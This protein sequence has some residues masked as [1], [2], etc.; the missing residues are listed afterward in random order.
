M[1]K[2]YNSNNVFR[3]VS[4]LFLQL[5]RLQEIK[6]NIHIRE[7]GKRF[8]VEKLSHRRAVYLLNPFIASVSV[9]LSER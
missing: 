1:C 3:T 6:N 4:L 8:T 2:M 5:T 9:A 7:W